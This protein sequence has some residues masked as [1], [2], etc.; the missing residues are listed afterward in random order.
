MSWKPEAEDLARRRAYADALGGP[1]A[2]EKHHSQ[3]RLTVRERIDGLC[4]AGSFQE[5]GKL[6]GKGT[7]EDG[8]LVKVVPAPYVMGLATIDG[9]P[10]KFDLHNL[11]EVEL[12]RTLSIW[13]TSARRKSSNYVSSFRKAR[14]RCAGRHERGFCSK[15]TTG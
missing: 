6:T 15:P 9:R 12:W 10:V 14:H 2:I 7:Y 13:W 5:V 11:V 8:K 1:K 3:G 4:D